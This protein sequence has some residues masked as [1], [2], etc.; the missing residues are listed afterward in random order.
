MKAEIR[1]KYGYIKEVRQLQYL[2]Y[3]KNYKGGDVQEMKMRQSRRIYN[4]S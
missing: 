4:V 3:F 2:G 1:T